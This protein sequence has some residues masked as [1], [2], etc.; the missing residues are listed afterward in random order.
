[1]KIETFDKLPK[2]IQSIIQTYNYMTGQFLYARKCDIIYTYRKIVWKIK[3][4]PYYCNYC[5]CDDCK[6]GW[7]TTYMKHAPTE[8][9]KW[10][11]DVCYT[12]DVCP[13]G[14][15]EDENG[16]SICCEHRPKLVG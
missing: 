7:A 14:P 10:I 11:C 16:K 5:S 8:D 2:P 15:C 6:Y 9:G 1:M 12:Y 13:S 4:K 3:K